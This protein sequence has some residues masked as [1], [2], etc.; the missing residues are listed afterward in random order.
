M[1]RSSNGGKS[2]SGTQKDVRLVDSVVD[3]ISTLKGL[4]LE[5]L[6]ADDTPRFVEL[7]AEHGL[8]FEDGLHLAV[9]LR[10]GLKEIV[11]N[12]TDFERAGLKRAF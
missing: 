4:A 9:A 1:G 12:D 3:P 10:M 7:M 2:L 6:T 11:S 8:D 5:P